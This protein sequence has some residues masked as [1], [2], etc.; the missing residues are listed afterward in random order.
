MARLN[1]SNSLLV[2]NGTV[3]DGSGAA[4]QIAD[5]R[6]IDGLITEVGSGLISQGEPEFNASG[7]TVAPGFV[8][9][10]THLDAALFWSPSCDP[11]P[12][13]GV[14][15][16]VM[17]N[18]SLSLA[19]VKTAEREGL[20][21][22]FGHIED[23]PIDLLRAE[24]PFSWESYPDYISAINKNPTG[25]R[26]FGLLGHSMLRSYVLGEQAWERSSTEQE[27]SKIVQLLEEALKAGAIGLSSSRFDRD[28]AGRLVP[29]AL[30]DE[31]ERIELIAMLGK[32]HRHLQFIPEIPA[33]ET[34]EELEWTAKVC[35]EYDVQ[36]SWNGLLDMR[37]NRALAD[38]L[39]NKMHEVH[40][41]Y[42]HVYTQVSPR[43]FDASVHFDETFMFSF[44]PVWNEV[45][46]ADGEEKWKLLAD[47]DFRQRARL[48]WDSGP[49]QLFP[50]EALETLLIVDTDLE[51]KEWIGRRFNERVAFE[52][53]HPSDVLADWLLRNKLNT[54]F[55]A[56][57]VGNEDAERMR[58]MLNHPTS[59][60]GSG[61]AA[62]HIKMMCGSGDTTRLLTK[63]VRERGDLSLAE[64]IRHITSRPAE[65]FGLDKVGKIAP[66][67]AGDL[68]IFK[69]ENLNWQAPELVDDIPGG[70]NRYRRPSGGYAATVIG[71]TFV[72]RDGEYTGALPATFETLGQRSAKQV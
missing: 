20:L 38:S 12:L 4:G 69:L 16:A 57:G 72:Q 53:R 27:R 24:I 55:M 28:G 65:I 15:S 71:G 36:S 14:T 54:V 59:I 45:I 3:I 47:K 31:Q 13:H 19:P 50:T 2:R 35:A 22:I 41:Q 26:M 63:H 67:F 61:D 8:D 29:S 52:N 40:E 1:Q 10:H 58:D 18:C 21:N 25:L 33:E 70:G 39:L 7:Y 42:G 68:V 60:V 11:M 56:L 30:A 48:E 5:I 66:G 9:I 44:M 49:E 23:L 62:A 17:G 34:M 32:Y 46:Q 6:I 51:D 37:A 64:G 43:P